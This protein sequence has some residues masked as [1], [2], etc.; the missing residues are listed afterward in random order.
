MKASQKNPLPQKT[1]ESRVSGGKESNTASPQA[2]CAAQ[3]FLRLPAAPE[4]KLKGL[5]REFN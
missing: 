3:L 5:L 2:R 1:R 4:G